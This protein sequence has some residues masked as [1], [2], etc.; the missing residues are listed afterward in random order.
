LLAIKNK[1][2]QMRLNELN[3]DIQFLSDEKNPEIYNAPEAVDI[4]EKAKKDLENCINRAD[5][6]KIIRPFLLD[7]KVVQ[8]KPSVNQYP[9]YT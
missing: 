5:S 7:K 6:S 1:I 8:Q 9:F 3:N 4:Y 2:E